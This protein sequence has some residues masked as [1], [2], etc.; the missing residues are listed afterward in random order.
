MTST[1]QRVPSPRLRD[2][3]SL[4]VP[5]S[6]G[7]ERAVRT[8]GVEE[9]L[10]L[11]DA[12]TGVVRAL[13]SPV[14]TSLRNVPGARRRSAPLTGQGA[15]NEAHLQQIEV[16]TAPAESLSALG[17]EVR[18]WRERL[19]IAA[20]EHG[21]AVLASGTA[22][23]RHPSALGNRKRYRTMDERFGLTARETMTCGLHVHVSVGSHEEGV[24]VLDRIRP[25]LPVVLALSV[26][27]PF[28]QG[29][30]SGFGSYRTQVFGRWPTSGPSDIHGSVEAHDARM[31]MLLAS[32]VPLDRSALYQD[33]RRSAKYPTV[34]VRVADVCLHSEESVALAGLV[35]ALVSTAARE[36]ERG[37]A[38]DPVPTDVLRLASWR[39]SHDGLTGMLLD[40]RTHKPV[41]ARKAVR[42]LL[43]HVSHDLDLTGDTTRVRSGLESLVREGGGAEVQ[44]RA[45]RDS[46]DLG[47][48]VTELAARTA[49][50]WGVARDLSPA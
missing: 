35:R 4:L 7:E 23:M 48:A 22:P 14:L 49:G 6:A 29:Q 34:E 40:P 39:A 18:A 43:A 31:E 46:R 2:G 47:K 15:S 30:D 32:G 9:E 17:E 19:S 5:S 26:N 37:V 24:G 21:C 28:W 36:W 44:R 38:P 13:A 50:V 12:E 20:A 1:A 41:P 16:C 42:S 11:V 3:A 45:Y 33:A 8:V 27:S 25:W 10:L